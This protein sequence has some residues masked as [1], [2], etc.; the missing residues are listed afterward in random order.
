MIAM[1][2][3]LFCTMLLAATHLRSVSQNFTG[4]G[5][6]IPS[7]LRIAKNYSYSCSC[8]V[9]PPTVKESGIMLLLLM[10]GDVVMNPGP[11]ML[12]SVNAR[13][14]RNKGPLLADTI[15]SHGFDFLCLTD[16][17]IRTTDSDSFLRSLTPDG[18]SLIHR[19]CST[20]IG[21]GVG[22]FIRESF[23]Y[24]KVDT[25]N[26][27]SFENIV[28]SI[29]V[30]CRTLLLAS[31]Y[32]P[33]GPCSSIF[34]DEFMSFVCFLSSV[35]CNY[36]I[37]GDLNIHVD[38]SCTDS[39]KLESLLDSCNLT[40]SVNNT[41][42]LLGHILDFILSPIDQDMC[43]HVDIC[44]FISDHAAIKCAIHFPSSLA[45][46][47][48]RISYRR[49]HRINMSNFRSDLK[50]IYFCEMSSKFCLTAL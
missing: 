10:C 6:L 35:D 25:P 17:H 44:E 24:H 49:Y 28:I 38:V 15:A 14:I 37:C 21:G 45:N 16:T 19:P 11:V 41:T 30:S 23:K 3:F 22:F 1:R 5:F 8:H 31:T 18:F 40:Q 9:F 26:Y 48:K 4:S 47:Q 42:H 33:P 29:S 2:I 36:F 27:S 20:G 34:L 43:V 13:S 12:G 7:M 32:H 46:C 50:D 39:Y